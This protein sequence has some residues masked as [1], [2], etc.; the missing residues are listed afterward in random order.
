MDA[1]EIPESAILEI[2][3]R[4]GAYL[5]GG[6]FRLASGLHAEEYVDFGALVRRVIPAELELLGRAV[7]E[8][9]RRS[10]L[11]AAQFICVP[12][13]DAEVL[14]REVGKWLQPQPRALVVALKRDKGMFVLDDTKARLLRRWSVLLLDDVVSTGSTLDKLERLV[15]RA[16]GV[17][18]GRAVLWA[19]D[20]RLSV[21]APVRRRIEAWAPGPKNCPRCEARVPIDATVGHGAEEVKS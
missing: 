20:P 13:G 17:I 1:G 12:S 16:K 8:E 10:G 5:R 4:H 6:H 11:A 14:A 7:A 18:V 3:E 19:R 21:A 2:F 15:E 9:V